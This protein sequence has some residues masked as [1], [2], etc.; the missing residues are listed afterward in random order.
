MFVIQ[1]TSILPSF[2]LIVLK[3]KKKLKCNFDYVATN[4]ANVA[5][6]EICGFH[7]NT[8]IKLSQEQN[9]VFSS[10]KKK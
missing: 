4:Y 1:H 7:R 5:E 6:F 8:K 10:N 3:I 2:I 9:I